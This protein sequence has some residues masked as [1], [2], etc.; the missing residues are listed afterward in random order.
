M[1]LGFSACSDEIIEP[2]QPTDPAVGL[3]SGDIYNPVPLPAYPYIVGPSSIELDQLY[4]FQANSLTV[5]DTFTFTV[6]D[7]YFH[8]PKS[9]AINISPSGNRINV[10]FNDYGHYK[11]TAKSKATGKECSYEVAKYY[12]EV[13]SLRHYSDAPGL[14]DGFDGGRG[15]EFSRRLERLGSNFPQRVVINT[16]E[17][18]MEYWYPFN[19]DP[20]MKRGSDLETI[21]GVAAKGTNRINLPDARVVLHPKYNSWTMDYRALLVPFCEQEYTIPEERCG[22][23]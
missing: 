8:D 5:N 17:Y 13:G 21:T 2:N 22:A 6:E 19:A 14:R 1:L 15:K 23:L 12:K 18:Y 4:T 10:V 16:L 9:Y 7:T 3:V 11:I 20:Y